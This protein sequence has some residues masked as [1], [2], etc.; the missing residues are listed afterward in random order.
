MAGYADDFSKSAPN[1]RFAASILAARLGV[2]KALL[3]AWREPAKDVTV[4]ENCTG[5]Y[6]EWSWSG[7]RNPHATEI[8]FGPVRVTKKGT[9]FTLE[10]PSGT[11]RKGENTRG[12]HLFDSNGR[13][14]TLPNHNIPITW[15]RA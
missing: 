5:S 7:T 13:R 4:L 14:L 12:F 6:L 3:R 11:I 9:W 10:L 2:I 1:G 8:K 15:I